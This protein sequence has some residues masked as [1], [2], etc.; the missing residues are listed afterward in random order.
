MLVV[1][2]LYPVDGGAADDKTDE[3]WNENGMNGFHFY[4]SLPSKVTTAN[5]AEAPLRY[6][7]V[8]CTS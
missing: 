1:V 4:P 2:M 7:A 5:G 8:R 6:V 3:K